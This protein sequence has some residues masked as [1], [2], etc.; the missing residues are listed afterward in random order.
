MDKKKFEKKNLSRTT[1]YDTHYA[2][3]IN[4]A[5]IELYKRISTK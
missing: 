5:L 2:L 4:K 3:H 1:T